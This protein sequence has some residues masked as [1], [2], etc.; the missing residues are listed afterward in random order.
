MDGTDAFNATDSNSEL[1]LEMK[2]RLKE[3]HTWWEVPAIAHFCSLFKAVFGFSDFDIEDLEEALLTSPALGGSTLV[4]DIICQLLN[5][6]YARDDIKYFNYDL[7]LKDIFKQRWQQELGRVNPLSD[8]TFLDLP[9]RQRVEILHALCD[10]RLDADDVAEMLKGLSG[11]SLRVEPLGVDGKG[12]KYWYF[13][14]TRLYKELLDNEEIEHMTSKGKRKLKQQEVVDVNLEREENDILGEEQG[15]D[16]TKRNPIL[17]A[18]PR[19]A[20]KDAIEDEIED[21]DEDLKDQDMEEKVEIPQPEEDEEDEAQKELAEALQE[22]DDDVMDDDENDVDFEDELKK[23]KKTVK[24]QKKKKSVQK[25]TEEKLDSEGEEMPYIESV[26]RTKKKTN[27]YKGGRS[28]SRSRS[29]GSKTITPE[30]TDVKQNNCEQKRKRG[31][32]KNQEPEATPK[33]TRRS[34]RKMNDDEPPEIIFSPNISKQE[35]KRLTIDGFQNQFSTRRSNT[36]RDGSVSGDVKEESGPSAESDHMKN[37]EKAVS[38]LNANALKDVCDE[39]SKL[40]PIIS[41]DLQDNSLLSKKGSSRRKS[42]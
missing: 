4:V 40:Q 32:K 20:E 1:D 39:T 42:T 16:K 8:T 29:R 11:D 36:S 18:V 5:G 2:E 6:C 22:S 31:P 19:M 13:Y 24:S 41:S 30:A 17:A 12:A 37:I 27:Y 15:A 34:R 33:P 21:P 23:K 3:V 35:L 28:K 10:F 25:V 38:K 7:F 26:V 9:V 14:G